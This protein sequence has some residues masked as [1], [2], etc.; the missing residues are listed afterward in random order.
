MLL[1]DIGN[2]R[3]HIYN[4]KT[5]SHLSHSQ[6]LDKFKNEK[7]YYISVKHQLKDRLKSMKN[8]ID[9][10]PKLKLKNSYKTMG[11]DR[12][13]LCLSR[14]N[15]IFIS[16]GTAITVDIVEDEVYQ[17]GFI[18]LGIR[19]YL[20]GYANISPAL[21]TKLNPNVSMDK[22]PKTT[23]D[24]ISYG[25]IASIKTLIEKVQN[26]KQLYI[27]GGDGE[28]LSSFFD[29]AIFDESLIFQGMQTVLK[30]E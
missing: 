17:G 30:G 13:A 21:K 24:S 27:S 1:A 26:G 20:N 12:K 23:K 10:S 25:I 29:N 11:V 4:G 22:L 3:V 6:A 14:K 18:L 8:W 5:I 7:I 28:L 16:A 19:A 9:I 2:S 15:G